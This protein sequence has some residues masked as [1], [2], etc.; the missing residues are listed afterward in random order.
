LG[1][2]LLNVGGGFPAQYRTPVPMLWRSGSARRGASS[3]T[4]KSECER[5]PRENP[6]ASIALGR[7]QGMAHLRCGKLR[8]K[9]RLPGGARGIRT[10]GPPWKETASSRPRRNRHFA[11][12]TGGLNLARSVAV[13][14]GRQSRIERLCQ[15][16][17]SPDYSA[18]RTAGGPSVRSTRGLTSLIISS[19]ERIA[20]L[21][22]VAP[23]LN[24][25]HMWT[26]CVVVS[27]FALVFILARG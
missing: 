14:D 7:G 2:A 21:C 12:G 13:E 1:L 15:P 3:P 24:E 5:T 8:P 19:I 26:G 25:K 16:W 10:A 17:A 9:D 6:A 18:A 20:A 27:L 22:G 4:A 11:R 23:T